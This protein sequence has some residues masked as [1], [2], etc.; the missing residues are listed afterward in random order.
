MNPHQFAIPIRIV[1][2]AGEPVLEIFNVDEAV[3]FLISRPEGDHDIERQK[4]VDAC[5]A[6]TLGIGSL[7]SARWMLLR[8]ARD[9]GVI[10]R[11]TPAEAFLRHRTPARAG[12]RSRSAAES[13]QHP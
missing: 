9:A 12:A 13:G 10:S 3:D 1:P 5:F 6:V 7:E 4:A 8:Y 11:D 2:R